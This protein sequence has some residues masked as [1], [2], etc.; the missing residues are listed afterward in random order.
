MQEPLKRALTLMTNA[1]AQ[2][3]FRRL[4]RLPDP[5]YEKYFLPYYSQRILQEVISIVCLPPSSV[6]FLL[7][8]MRAC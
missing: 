2:K 1:L 7:D 8:G 3:Q 4:S 5:E 6:Y